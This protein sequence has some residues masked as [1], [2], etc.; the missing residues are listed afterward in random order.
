MVFLGLTVENE[1]TLIFKLAFKI[2]MNG[3]LDLMYFIFYFECYF[4]A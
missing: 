2:K 1:I 3:F 4:W